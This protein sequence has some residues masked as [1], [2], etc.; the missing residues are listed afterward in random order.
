M[1]KIS[2]L[3][4]ISGSTFA[5]GLATTDNISYTTTRNERATDNHDM[6]VGFMDGFGLGINLG[7]LGSGLNVSHY[8]YKDYLTLRANINYLP[9]SSNID[10]NNYNINMNTY[11]LL[12]D[13]M[14]F[15]GNFRLTGGLYYNNN[16]LQIANSGSTTFNGETYNGVD[17]SSLKGAVTFN[18]LSPYLGIGI[19]SKSAYAKERKGLYVSADLGVLYALPVVSLSATCNPSSGI[20]CNQF[21]NNLN[22]ERNNLQNILNTYGQFYPVLDIGLGYRF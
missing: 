10:G 16:S 9:Y 21:Y 2:L 20:D 12:L 22:M 7:T 18:P 6:Q 5:T 19:G 4:L 3:L 8:L 15:A 1:K 11:G 14:P 17:Y 13:Y